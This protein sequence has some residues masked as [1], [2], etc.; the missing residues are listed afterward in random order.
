MVNSIE[1]ND[2]TFNII[3]EK[4]SDF[5]YEIGSEILRKV[6]ENIDDE[7]FSNRD[8]SIYRYKE[9]RE[10][11]INT[12]FGS[13]TYNRRYYKEKINRHESRSM[14]LLDEVLDMDIL[15]RSTI[16]KAVN[17]AIEAEAESFRDVSRKNNNLING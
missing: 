12:C 6:L 11:S 14:F 2:L 10:C 17:L 5:L 7:L 8:K 15:G 3:E 13:V 1:Y 4:I 16:K 9:K